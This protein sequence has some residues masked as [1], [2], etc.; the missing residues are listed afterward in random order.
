MGLWRYQL[1]SQ[2]LNI[3]ASE[4]SVSQRC[5][6]EYDIIINYCQ[7]IFRLIDD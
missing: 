7:V 4:V 5:Y 3:G 6:Y 1:V 2:P